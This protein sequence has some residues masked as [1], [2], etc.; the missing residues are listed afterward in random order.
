[1]ARLAS[2]SIPNFISVF[3]RVLVVDGRN[4]IVK[5]SPIQNLQDESPNYAE[6]KQ[7]ARLALISVF[8][9]KVRN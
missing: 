4:Q 7:V 1:M 8:N 9:P 2:P 3:E 6:N 5:R